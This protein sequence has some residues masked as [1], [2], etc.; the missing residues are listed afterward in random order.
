[1]TTTEGGPARPVARIAADEL[2]D[3]DADHR[4]R[5][6]DAQP[7]EQRRQRGR[8]LDLPEDLRSRGLEGAGEVDQVRIDCAHGSQHIDQYREEHDQDRDQNLRIDREAHPQD[9]QRGK[10]DFWRDLQ[11]QDVGR[12]RELGHGRHAEQIAHGGSHEAA[13]DEAGQHLARRDAS[14][15][16]QA[17]HMPHPHGFARHGGQRRN[18]ER[19]NAEEPRAPFPAGEKNH[20]QQQAHRRAAA[21]HRCVAHAGTRWSGAPTEPMPSLSIRWFT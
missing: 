3:H 19:R 8:K 14:V 7:R 6:A 1:M 11:R 2:A 12:Q 9:E 17:A 20:Q 21:D 15:R 13:D 16:E 5:R 18:D 10:R 4:E